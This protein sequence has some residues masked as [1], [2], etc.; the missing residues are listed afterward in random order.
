MGGSGKLRV[1]GLDLSTASTGMSDGVSTLV[2]QTSPETPLEER[3]DQQVRGVVG[4]ILSRTAGP[5][6][7]A[8]IEAGAFSRGSQSQAAE[9][10]SALRFMVR[11]RLWRFGIPYAMVSPTTLKKYVT[12]HGGATKQQ[13]VA[14]VDDRYRTGLAGVMV[15]DGRYDRADAF[16]LAAMGYDHVG[17]PLYEHGYEACYPGPHRDSLHAVAWPDLTSDN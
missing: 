10:L 1:V 8:V 9:I 14:S 11:H 6:D 13:M 7:L 3:L 2:V 17:Q 15:R 16:A 4:F 5:A 12:G